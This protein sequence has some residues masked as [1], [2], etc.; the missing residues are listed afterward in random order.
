MDAPYTPDR[1]NSGCTQRK[2]KFVDSATRR[3]RA[4]NE[5]KR[6]AQL[7]L[8]EPAAGVWVAVGSESQPSRAFVRGPSRTTA[9]GRRLA[10]R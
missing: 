1:P 7:E 9:R 3:V 10:A 6:S 4:I 5:G 2:H 8:H